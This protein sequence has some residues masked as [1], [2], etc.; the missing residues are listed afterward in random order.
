MKVQAIVTT[1]MLATLSMGA[2]ASP[3]CTSAAKEHWMPEATMKQQLEADGYAIH[4]FKTTRGNC[5]EI[6]GRDKGGEKV[7]IYFNPVDGRV[8]KEKRES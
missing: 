5:Y 3:E 7:E 1:A 6:Y 2:S 8:V 4:K